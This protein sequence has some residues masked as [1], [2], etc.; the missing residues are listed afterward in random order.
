MLCHLPIHL[1]S[2]GCVFLGDVLQAEHVSYSAEVVLA[3]LTFVEPIVR[4]RVF[5]L[6]RMCLM[7]SRDNSY[8]LHSLVACMPLDLGI[9]DL[10]GQGLSKSGTA[11]RFEDLA[12]LPRRRSAQF[13]SLPVPPNAKQDLG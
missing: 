9:F 1:T 10:S 3:W 6:T 8:I 11:S 12:T 7:Q 5:T 4:H 13:A 2:R